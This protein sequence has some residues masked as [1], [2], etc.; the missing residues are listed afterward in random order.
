[1]PFEYPDELREHIFKIWAFDADRKAGRAIELA[2]ASDLAGEFDL[3]QL[4]RRTV[5]R[6]ALGD[7]WHDRANR[8]LY[9]E[10]YNLRFNT[11]GTLALA[12]PQ[13]AARLREASQMDGWVDKPI[14][15]KDVDQKTG[16]PIERIEMVRVLDVNV[17]RAAVQ[18]AQVILDRS[19][20]SPVGTREIGQL[21]APP[22][23]ERTNA[24]ELETISRIV[25][26]QEKALALAELEKRIRRD[27]VA[28]GHGNARLNGRARTVGGSG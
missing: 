3:S 23:G 7:N 9:V 21:S 6:W 20:F 10:R 18:A 14:T 5:N 26:P 24:G 8:E 22:E 2:L 15:V 16:L 17:L 12:A 19:G 4:D 28:I 1:M 13:A 11:E 25:D 27:P